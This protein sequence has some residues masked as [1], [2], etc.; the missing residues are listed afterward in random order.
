MLN[1]A[2]PS[3]ISSTHSPK[4]AVLLLFKKVKRAG[5]REEIRRTIS[6]RHHGKSDKQK[7]LS[8]EQP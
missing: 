3:N 6:N 8:L 2:E 1:E 4:F 5:S 7:L